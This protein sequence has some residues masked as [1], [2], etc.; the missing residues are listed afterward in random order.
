[1]NPFCNMSD[2]EDYLELYCTMLQ[3]WSDL[4]YGRA[5][6]EYHRKGSRG[7]LFFVYEK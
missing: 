5:I 4:V 3:L 1:M 2:L 6:P 7:I